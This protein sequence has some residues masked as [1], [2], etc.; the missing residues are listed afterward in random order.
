MKEHEFYSWSLFLE[1]LLNILV[2]NPE[3]R[4]IIAKT[5]RLQKWSDFNEWFEIFQ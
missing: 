1:F 4:N 3:D 5:H 2:S